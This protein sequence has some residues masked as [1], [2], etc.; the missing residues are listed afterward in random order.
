LPEQ[1]QALSDEVINRDLLPLLAENLF[2]LDFEVLRRR[3]CEF[4]HCAVVNADFRR[5]KKT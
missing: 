3:R 1:V 2:R 5:R 4:L